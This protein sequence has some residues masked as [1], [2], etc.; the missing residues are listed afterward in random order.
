MKWLVS[1]EHSVRLI[2]S[3]N[4]HWA[5]LNSGAQLFVPQFISVGTKIKVNVYEK[6]YVEKIAA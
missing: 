4:Q 2:D 1:C 5:T 6:E 3:S